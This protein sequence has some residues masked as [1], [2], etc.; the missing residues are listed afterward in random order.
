VVVVGRVKKND[1]KIIYP[2]GKRQALPSKRMLD[3][4]PTWSM[5]IIRSPRAADDL[6][7]NNK[8]IF[9]ENPDA[10]RAIVNNIHESRKRIKE[11]PTQGRIVP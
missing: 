11:F 9:R 7:E 6:V 3:G 1:W 2:A 8:Y 4:H 10:A 5:K